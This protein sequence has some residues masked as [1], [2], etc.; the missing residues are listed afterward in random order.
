MS[1]NDGVPIFTKSA[2]LVH[3]VKYISYCMCQPKFTLTVNVRSS[4]QSHNKKV[5]IPLVQALRLCTGRTAHRVGRGIALL[6]RH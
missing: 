4:F 3:T 6:Y 2:T 5:K 1:A